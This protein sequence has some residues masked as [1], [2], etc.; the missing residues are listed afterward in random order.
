MCVLPKSSTDSIGVLQAS[1][2][3]GINGI[4]DS[5]KWNTFKNMNSR[6]LLCLAYNCYYGHVPE[7]LQSLI[8]KKNYA[9]NF[10]RKL[11]LALPAPKSNFV[12]NSTLE[13]VN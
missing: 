2:Y 7:P 11:T 12:R 13:F 8:S 6:R 1:K 5:A 3:Y 9:Y 10:K 4:D